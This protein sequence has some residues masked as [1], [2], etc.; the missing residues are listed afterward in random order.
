MYPNEE[1]S[2]LLEILLLS[3]P[4]RDLLGVNLEDGR[5]LC[6]HVTSSDRGIGL[7][8]GVFI[9]DDDDVEH[10]DNVSGLG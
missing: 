6:L 9:E 2:S 5:G 1:L 10:T 3:E 8:F 7:H 4:L